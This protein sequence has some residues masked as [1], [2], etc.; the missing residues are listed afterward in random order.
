MDVFAIISIW[1]RGRRFPSGQLADPIGLVITAIGSAI[2]PTQE[3][4]HDETPVINKLEWRL[5]ASAC[6]VFTKSMVTK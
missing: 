1:V 4:Q 3:V 2:C 6:A 5:C